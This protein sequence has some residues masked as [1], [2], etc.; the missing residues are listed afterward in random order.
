[1]TNA[2]LQQVT[3]LG[4]IRLHTGDKPYQCKVCDKY[5]SDL[6]NLKRH[7]RIHTGDKPYKCTVCGKGFRQSAHLTTHIRIHKK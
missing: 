7:L 1:M 3:L 5:F 6:S 4:H 2:S